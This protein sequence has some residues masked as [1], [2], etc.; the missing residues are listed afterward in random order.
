MDAK[1]VRDTLKRVWDFIWNDNSVWSWVVNIILA[2]VLIKFVIYPALGFALQTTHPIVA[3]VSGSMEHRTVHPC[4]L[5][6]PFNAARCIQVDKSAYEICGK[7]F[8]SRQ[9]VNFDFF[10][11]ACGAWYIG[12]NVTKS[13]FKDMSFVN[14]F[15]KGDIMVLYG[16][17]PKDI[18]VGD[19]IV[20]NGY[21]QE[22][23]IHRVVKVTERDGIFYFQTKGD[24]NGVSYSFEADIP[25]SRYIG[26][27][28][29]RIPWLG[30]VKILAV[31]F[32][33]LLVR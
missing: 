29:A 25:E 33:N 2:F 28:V 16:T 3:V 18:R 23:I 10:W 27:A 15:N 20:F 19:I 6:D 21:M 32:I 11:D 9:D 8:S 17:K 5:S 14:G 31:D 12:N 24:H 13:E 26:R 30:Y 22:P 4:L 1:K 7:V